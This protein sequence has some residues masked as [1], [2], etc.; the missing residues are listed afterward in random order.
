MDFVTTALQVNFRSNNVTDL[1]R[2]LQ[3]LASMLEKVSM[4]ANIHII[5]PRVVFIDS[6]PNLP[7]TK[8]QNMSLGPGSTFKMELDTTPVHCLLYCVQKLG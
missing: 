5:Q 4:H 8:E 2:R 7:L 1:D 6:T 3:A